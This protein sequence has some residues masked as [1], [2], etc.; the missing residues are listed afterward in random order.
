MT[1]YAYGRFRLPHTGHDLLFSICDTV[2]CSKSPSAYH[3]VLLSE[4]SGKPVVNVPAGSLLDWAQSNMPHCG[5]D[6]L[7]L[8]SDNAKLGERLEELG[9]CVQYVERP[10]G[11]PSSTECRRQLIKFCADAHLVEQGLQADLRK[12]AI[13][14]ELWAKG[15]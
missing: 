11:A 7:V 10:Q 6:T 14:R 13:A 12:A 1:V 2:V 5:E 8:G 3:Q 15:Y 9:F 4:Y